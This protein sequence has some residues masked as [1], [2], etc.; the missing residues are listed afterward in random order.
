MEINIYENKHLKD[1][2]VFT[3]RGKQQFT[4]LTKYLQQYELVFKRCNKLSLTIKEQYLKDIT[5]IT[6]ETQHLKNGINVFIT[7]E[8]KHLKYT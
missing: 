4:D 2:Q 3:T 5:N 8:E 7:N 6:T 1:I